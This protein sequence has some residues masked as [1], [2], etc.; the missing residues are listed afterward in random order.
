M[1]SDAN[2]TVKPSLV[3]SCLNLC[4]EHSR[5]YRGISVCF[6]PVVLAINHILLSLFCFRQLFFYPG[7]LASR[8]AP[9]LPPQRGLFFC[10]L[11]HHRC[12]RSKHV[13]LRHPATAGRLGYQRKTLSGGNKNVGTLRRVIQSSIMFAWTSQIETSSLSGNETRLT[14]F[15]WYAW[16]GCT[17]RS[18]LSLGMHMHGFV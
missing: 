9:P 15:A 12:L 3:S 6:L 1:T 8:R 13:P 16:G 4:L 18:D 5:N 11:H 14:F 17:G 7:C 10:Y 2:A